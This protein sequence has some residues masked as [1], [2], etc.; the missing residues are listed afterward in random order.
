[1]QRQHGIRA[2][3]EVGEGVFKIRL[4]SEEFHENDCVEVERFIRRQLEEEDE[5][6]KYRNLTSGPVGTATGPHGKGGGTSI[7]R[8]GKLAQYR[9]KAGDIT[10]ST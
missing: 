10:S 7:R 6:M 3:M 9:N 2:V 1:M 5:Q 8:L 4:D